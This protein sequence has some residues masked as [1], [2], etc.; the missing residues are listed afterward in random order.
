MICILAAVL[1]VITRA[2]F[3]DDNRLGRILGW[4]WLAILGICVVIRLAMYFSKSN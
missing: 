4:V 1:Y 2:S 3:K